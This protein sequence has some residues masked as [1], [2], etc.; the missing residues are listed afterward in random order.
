MDISGIQKGISNKAYHAEQ[1]HISSSLLRCFP[2]RPEEYA[3][4]KLNGR[5]EIREKEG[6]NW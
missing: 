6:I 1:A 3:A 4:L 5:T 2:D